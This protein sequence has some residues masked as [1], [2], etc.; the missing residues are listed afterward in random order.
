M[1]RGRNNYSEGRRV[2]CTWWFEGRCVGSMMVGVL[3]AAGAWQ[4]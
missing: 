4:V 3:L 1:G 2:L